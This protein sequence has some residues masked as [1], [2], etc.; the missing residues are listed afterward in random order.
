MLLAFLIKD[1]PI[2]QKIL[3]NL[4]YFTYSLKNVNFDKAFQIFMSFQIRW[5]FILLKLLFL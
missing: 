4:N 5:D 3:L 2:L 1:H